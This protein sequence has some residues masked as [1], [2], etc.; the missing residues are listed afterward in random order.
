MNGGGKG[1][2]NPADNATKVFVGG[3]P[4]GVMQEEIEAYFGNFGTVKH[5]EVKTDPMTGKSRGFCFVPFGDEASMEATISAY[6]SH[7]LRG[8]WIEVK[9]ATVGGTSGLAAGK[10]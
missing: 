5:V 10:A 3:L 2:G 1:G 8:K 4:Q 9:K 6:D 7:E